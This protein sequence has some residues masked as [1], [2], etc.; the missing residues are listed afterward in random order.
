MLMVLLNVGDE[1]PDPDLLSTDG[2]AERGRLSSERPLSGVLLLV[3][4]IGLLLLSVGRSLS[5]PDFLKGIIGG[6][7]FG[8]GL[9]I[10]LSAVDDMTAS[11]SS[12]STSSRPDGLALRLDDCEDETAEL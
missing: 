4:D 5:E 6:S 1:V 12:S 2:S 10:T 7:T 8:L 11:S 3:N 9:A